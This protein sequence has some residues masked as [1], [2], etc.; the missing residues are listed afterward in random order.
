M[1]RV[2]EYETI[3]GVG[4]RGCGF[5]VSGW[6]AELCGQLCGLTEQPDIRPSAVA[7]GGEPANEA[8]AFAASHGRCHEVSILMIG[9]VG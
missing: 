9:S 6:C 8:S 2:I 5:W 4:R 7:G 3:R 1:L